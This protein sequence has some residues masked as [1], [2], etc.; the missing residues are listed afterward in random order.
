MKQLL[1]D[2]VAESKLGGSTSLCWG[3]GKEPQEEHVI[4]EGSGEEGTASRTQNTKIT[5]AKCQLQI[6]SECSGPGARVGLKK[7]GKEKASRQRADTGGRKG[8]HLLG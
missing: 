3:A 8:D 6:Q 5:N 1:T 2:K 4:L 7:G